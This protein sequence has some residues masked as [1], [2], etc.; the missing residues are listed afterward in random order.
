MALVATRQNL[1]RDLIELLKTRG[2]RKAAHSG[3][4]SSDEFECYTHVT[5]NLAA[6]AATVYRIVLDFSTA[7][8]TTQEETAFGSHHPHVPSESRK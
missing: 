5:G 1:I 8:L 7:T 4:P 2:L 6:P 3:N